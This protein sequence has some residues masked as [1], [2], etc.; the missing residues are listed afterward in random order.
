MGKI[1]W[2]RV[3]LGGLLAGAVNNLLQF[4]VNSLYLFREWRTVIDTRGLPSVERTEFTWLFTILNVLAG[5][6]VVWLYVM[7]R[8]RCGPGP[9][10]AVLAGLVFWLVSTMGPIVVWNW[11]G[12][13]T[14]LLALVWA[15]H[16]GTYTY[17]VIA[18]VMTV[19]GAWPYKE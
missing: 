8:P 3:L 19:V 12:M 1:N 2:G 16:L 9:K 18:V 11:S 7:F 13:F 14:P 5:V 4:A 6:F 10:T 17:L 15:T